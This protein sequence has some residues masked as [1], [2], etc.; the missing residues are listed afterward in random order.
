MG[1]VAKHHKQS[2]INTKYNCLNIKT[3]MLDI[4]TIIKLIPE[5]GGFDQ[6]IELGYVG[7]RN[8]RIKNGEAV[9]AQGRNMSTAA[10]AG[11]TVGVMLVVI[12]AVMAAFL[13]ITRQR[14]DQSQNNTEAQFEDN[15]ARE[16]EA[17]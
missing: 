13:F 10:A 17:N 9:P 11:S 15:E 4:S 12:V 6:F 5:V 7:Q 3:K 8:W 2:D 14:K 16:D 1:I